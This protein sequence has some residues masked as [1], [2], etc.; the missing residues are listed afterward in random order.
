[1]L[2]P[3]CFSFMF[4][5]IQEVHQNTSGV[6]PIPQELLKKYIIYAKEK[7]HPKL[8]AMDQDKVAKMYS[9]LRRESMVSSSLMM[10]LTYKILLNLY[11][12]QYFFAKKY[13]SAL[14]K[15]ATTLNEIQQTDILACSSEHAVT[16]NTA[17]IQTC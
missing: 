11:I 10:K 3:D 1:M 12:S 2:A 6:E 15:F 13:S 9:D 17:F 16:T 14:V 8:N 7:A 4:K 5:Y